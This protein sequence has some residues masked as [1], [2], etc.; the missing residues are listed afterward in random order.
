MEVSRKLTGVASTARQDDLADVDTSDK[1]VGLAERTTHTGLKSIGTGTRQHLVDTDDVVGVGADAEVEGL[2][3]G[4]LHHVPWRCV[5][6]KSSFSPGACRGYV[7][8]GA[9]T[10]SLEGLGGDL[11]ILVGDEVNAEGE[12]VDVGLLATEIEDANLGV[13]YTTVE[14]RLRV[15]LLSI[16]VSGMF[17]LVFVL[18]S[19]LAPF[20]PSLALQFHARVQRWAAATGRFFVPCSCSSGNISR[21]DGPF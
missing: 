14:A 16:T 11:L 6:R 3:T 4:G 21:D 20:P 10:G 5:S 19:P 13:G 12:L 9:N 8:V 7:L 17:F 15:R 2:L 18:P 1:A